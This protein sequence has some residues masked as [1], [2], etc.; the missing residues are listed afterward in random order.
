MRMLILA[1]A[2]SLIT[3]MPAS[4]RPQSETTPANPTTAAPSAS[5]PAPAIPEDKSSLEFQLTFG[6]WFPR[7]GGDVTLGDGDSISLDLEPD[8]GL[9]DSEISPNIELAVRFG[10]GWQVDASGFDFDTDSDSVFEGTGQFGDL[11]L[12]PGDAFS[13]S[14]DMTSAAVGVSYW[15]FRPYTRG[16]DNSRVDLWFAP[17]VAVRWV[18]VDQSLEIAGE[19]SEDADG[20]WLCTTASLDLLFRYDLADSFPIIERLEIAGHAD[21]GPAFGGDGG[22]AAHIRATIT[23]F[24]TDNVGVSFGYRLLE[25]D[26]ENDDYE[27]SG[28]LQ[29]LFAGVSIAF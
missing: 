22:F 13:S 2:V 23:A 1:S 19:G 21:V 6:A 29:G 11:S 24:V 14:F 7:L 28:G 20:D 17:G 4:A 12:D 25:M 16:I 26:V 15:W 9:D 5:S 27:L 10:E 18:G 3:S 8:L